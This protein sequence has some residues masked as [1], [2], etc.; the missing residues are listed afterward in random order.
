MSHLSITAA[1]GVLI[2]TGIVR[3]VPVEVRPE[4][5]PEPGR[6]VAR[7]PVLWL[8]G[9]IALCSAIAEGASS[10]WSA[11]FGVHERGLDESAAALVYAGFSVA[12]AVMRLLGERIETR[13]GAT[14]MLVVGALTAACGLFLAV[15]VPVAVCTY[16]GFALAG[17][18][19]A[20]AF[21][22]ALELAGASGRRADGGGGERELGFVS[23]IAYSGFL[24][25]P[26]MVGGVASALG[27][28]FSLVVV[29][30]IAATI[31]PLAVG[32][33]RARDRER[34]STPNGDAAHHVITTGD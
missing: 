4:Q 24:L 11:F 13:W 26:P 2:V 10:D 22:I 21:P 1:V 3:W 8:L 30:F 17:G 33:H 18:G 32:A 20:F 16:V 7:R 29:G 23:T 6:A 5:R 25:G 14:R 34:R 28:P 15:A 31:A 19:L 9:F 12:M 27:L